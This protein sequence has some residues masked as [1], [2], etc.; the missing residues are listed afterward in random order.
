MIISSTIVAVAADS[1]ALSPRADELALELDLP[2]C[3]P[4]CSEYSHILIYS[5][6]PVAARLELRAT[7]KDAPGPV[8]VDFVGGTLGFRT[9]HGNRNK[10]PLARAIGL[11]GRTLPAILDATAGLGRDAF[12]LAALGCRVTLVERS[13]L[14][15][16]LLRDGL[17]RALAADNTR[18]IA[19]RMQLHGGDAVTIMDRVAEHERPDVIYLDPMYPHRSKSALVKKEMRVVR[20]LVGEDVDAPQLLEAALRAARKRVVVKRPR[21]APAL[22]GIAPSHSLLGSTTRFDVYVRANGVGNG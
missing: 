13:P 20:A 7:Y 22:P 19:E 15:A 14:I 9:R 2:R 1:V 10:E 5:S 17:A 4:P 6:A 21:P 8:Y 12:I 16:A 3:E 11:K 18:A